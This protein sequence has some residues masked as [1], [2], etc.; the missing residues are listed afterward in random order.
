M[1]TNFAEVVRFTQKTEQ[2]CPVQWVV[3]AVHAWDINT[4][5]RILAMF[6]FEL[7]TTI[8]R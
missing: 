6:V 4:V 3:Q 1:K 8:D 5:F 7:P 2:A